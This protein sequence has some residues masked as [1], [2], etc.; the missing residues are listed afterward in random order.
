MSKIG[1]PKNIF[2][3][4]LEISNDIKLALTFV[5]IGIFCI[6]SKLSQLILE[7]VNDK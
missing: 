2:F 4:K 7:H 5:I 3:G 1:N 6:L